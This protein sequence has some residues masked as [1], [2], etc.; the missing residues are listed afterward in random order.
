[1]PLGAVGSGWA[2]NLHEETAGAEE[3]LSDAGLELAKKQKRT[4]YRFDG[5]D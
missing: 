1:M 2:W 5:Y 4:F 3:I